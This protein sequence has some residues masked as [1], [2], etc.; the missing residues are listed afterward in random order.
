MLPLTRVFG[1]NVTVAECTAEGRG[2]ES[3]AQRILVFI[4]VLGWEIKSEKKGVF[5]EYLLA[6]S[7]ERTSSVGLRNPR[8]CRCPR[9]YFSISIS[10]YIVFMGIEISSS[11]SLSRGEGRNPRSPIA[12]PSSKPLEHIHV[13]PTTKTQR[14]VP[15]YVTAYSRCWSNMTQHYLKMIHHHLSH[16]IRT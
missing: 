14:W 2:I 16:G 15:V 5:L 13:Q 7:Y 3:R 1:V 11:R 9:Y 12:F 8:L 6:L 4:S 10:L